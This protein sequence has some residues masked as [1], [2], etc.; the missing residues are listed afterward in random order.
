[1][2][3]PG[4]GEA[5]VLSWEAPASCASAS[6]VRDRLDALLGGAPVDPTVHARARV[7]AVPDGFAVT[8]VL[9]SST[10]S[11]TRTIVAERCD[12]LAE[13]VVFV[14]AVAI[15]PVAVAR[16]VAQESGGASLIGPPAATM[17]SPKSVSTESTQVESGPEVEVDR[18]GAEPEPRSSRRPGPPTSGG[19]GAPPRSARTPVPLAGGLRVAT[20]VGVGVLPTFDVLLGVAGAL[21]GRSFRVELG[22][23]HGFARPARLPAAE[24]TGADLDQWTLLG[25]GCWARPTRRVEVALCG[26][27]E[28]G[29]VRARG[30]G[31][32][33]ART[34]WSSLVSLGAAAGLAVSLYGP[35]ALWVD[36]Q[37]YGTVRRP[38]F[39]VAGADSALYAASIG[40][41]RVGLGSYDPR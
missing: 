6:N 10:G 7:V 27:I 31:V 11:E 24:G 39:G 4:V 28:T 30:V 33:Q 12:V 13:A 34:R 23:Q 22:A 19:D 18:A 8:L 37:G 20:G 16:G 32:E 35:L 25:R 38:R 41:F 26:Q 5:P 17:P 2:L 36:L 3:G 21:R 29:A 15:D 14:V 40:G 9:S 1:M